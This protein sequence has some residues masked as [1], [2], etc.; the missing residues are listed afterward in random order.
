LFSR[1]QIGDRTG[2]AIATGELLNDIALAV[3]IARI[4]RT[5][6]LGGFERSGMVELASAS[7]E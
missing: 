5:K 7:R 6:L 1:S 4:R 2:T 3:G